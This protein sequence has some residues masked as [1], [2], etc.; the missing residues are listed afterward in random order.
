MK[1]IL[2]FIVGAVMCLSACKPANSDHLI[3]HEASLPQT[4]KLSDLHQKVITSFIN[5]RQHVSGVLYGNKKAYA[6]ATAE[7]PVA[8]PG[9]AFTLLTWQQQDDEHWFGARIPGNLLSAET[10]TLTGKSDGRGGYDYQRFLGKNLTKL[11]D[12]TGNAARIK[13]ILQQKASITP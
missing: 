5:N 1:L 10:L 12:T 7:K 6:A 9:Q 13:F 4:F 3:N 2:L 8:I 11:A